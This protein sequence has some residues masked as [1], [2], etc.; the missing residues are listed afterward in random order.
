MSEGERAELWLHM[1]SSHACGTDQHVDA[2]ELA[3]AHDHEHFGPGGIRNHPY[4]SRAFDEDKAI[5]V[6]H[7]VLTQ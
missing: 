4:E 1:L 5:T 6:L 7:E 2:D 3:A